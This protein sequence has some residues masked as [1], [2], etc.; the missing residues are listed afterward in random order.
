MVLSG[1]HSRKPDRCRT[2]TGASKLAL[3]RVPALASDRGLLQ[4]PVQ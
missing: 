2:K 1:Q 3:D 4:V